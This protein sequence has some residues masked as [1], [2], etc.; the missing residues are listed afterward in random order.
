VHAEEPQHAKQ[1]Q[2]GVPQ[3]ELKRLFVQ[4]QEIAFSKEAFKMAAN[5]CAGW[6]SDP[7]SMSKVAADF[8]LKSGHPN[9]FNPVTGCQAQDVT[10]TGP[11]CLVTYSCNEASGLKVRADLSNIPNFVTVG[12]GSFTPIIHQLCDYGY[13][14]PTDDDSNPTGA[15]IF[16]ELRCR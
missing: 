15:I 6:E 4:L 2:T 13:N 9:P 16:R 1:A 12:P 14:C 10:C 5:P 3:R 11:S 7:Q 8:Y